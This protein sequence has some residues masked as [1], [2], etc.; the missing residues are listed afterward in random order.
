MYIICK[1]LKELVDKM[2][3]LFEWMAKSLPLDKEIGS[4]VSSNENI[5]PISE[6]NLDKVDWYMVSVNTTA[7]HYPIGHRKMCKLGTLCGTE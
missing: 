6:Q 2:A 1:V 5:I 3:S 4:F 7:F